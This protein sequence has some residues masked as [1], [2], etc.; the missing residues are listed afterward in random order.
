MRAVLEGSVAAPRNG[1]PKSKLTVQLL[2]VLNEQAQGCA[3]SEELFFRRFGLTCDAP[4][5]QRQLD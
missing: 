4:P 1:M 5:A 2:V 3:C